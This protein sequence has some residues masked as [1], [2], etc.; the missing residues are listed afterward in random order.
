M[1]DRQRVTVIVVYH[2]LSPKLGIAGFPMKRKQSDEILDEFAL[3]DVPFEQCPISYY[4][5]VKHLH[6]QVLSIV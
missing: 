2:P 1:A 5:R 3:I 6:T 4:N